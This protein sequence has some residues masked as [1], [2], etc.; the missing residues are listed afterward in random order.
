MKIIKEHTSIRD[1]IKKNEK[2]KHISYDLPKVKDFSCPTAKT[3]CSK[4]N[5]IDSINSSFVFQT[6]FGDVVIP[7]SKI[8]AVFRKN[9]KHVSEY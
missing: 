1:L 2:Q 6:S 5:S 8:S 9:L 4:S 3:N 7:T